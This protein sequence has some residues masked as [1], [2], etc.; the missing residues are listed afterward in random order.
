[1]DRTVLQLGF[2]VQSSGKKKM[3]KKGRGTGVGTGASRLAARL[4]S[5]LYQG[6][7]LELAEKVLL[8]GESSLSG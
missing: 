5:V 6:T 1:L 2:A 7:T 8:E 4:K 3:W